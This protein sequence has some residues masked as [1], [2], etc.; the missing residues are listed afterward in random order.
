MYEKKK[1]L[2][3]LCENIGVTFVFTILM[4]SIAGW[5]FSNYAVDFEG[6]F[7]LGKHGLAYHGIAQ[8]FLF[9]IVMGVLLTVFTSDIY[10]KKVMLLWRCVIM[11]FI[12]LAVLL[13]F[14]IIFR[15]IPFGIWKA[16]AGLVISF[17]VFFTAGVT[18][19]IIKTKLDNR[20]YEKLLSEY[21]SRNNQN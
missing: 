17:V 3:I 1:V 15:W 14:V 10:L 6:P 19:F 16:W 4:A 8:F 18:P 9:A 21:K 12:A 7:I 20:R 11:L 13:L 5:I 2:R